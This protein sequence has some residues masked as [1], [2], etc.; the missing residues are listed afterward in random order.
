MI[1]VILAAIFEIIGDVLNL[2]HSKLGNYVPIR[3]KQLYH[4][5]LLGVFLIKFSLMSG[6]VLISSILQSNS[7]DLSH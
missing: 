7:G 5:V 6:L 4:T 2:R 3:V 1:F